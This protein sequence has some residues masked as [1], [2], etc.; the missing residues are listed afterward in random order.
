M[1]VMDEEAGVAGMVVSGG[2]SWA[3]TARP[4]GL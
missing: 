2:T 4:G 3:W 1:S